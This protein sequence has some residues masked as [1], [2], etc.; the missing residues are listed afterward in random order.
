M[1]LPPFTTLARRV[2]LMFMALAGPA[3]AQHTDDLSGYWCATTYYD[4]GA[5]TH[6]TESSVITIKMTGTTVQVVTSH[7]STWEGVYEPDKRV[8]RAAY[9][10][11]VVTGR[12]IL[13]LNPRG[14]VLEGEWFNHLG[15]SGRYVASRYTGPELPAGESTENICKNAAST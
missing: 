3:M 7:R 4:V 13:W 10:R 14:T 6:A 1:R 8:L 15:D 2:C 12:V 5:S 11:R 9:A